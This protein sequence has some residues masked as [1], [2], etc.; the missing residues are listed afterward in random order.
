VKSQLTSLF[1]LALVTA[2]CSGSTPVAP[3]GTTAG[4]T[5]AP[6]ENGV[7][8]AFMRSTAAVPQ[9]FTSDIEWTLTRDQCPALWSNSV[10]GT[11]VSRTKVRIDSLGN[12]TF[13]ISKTETVV[14]TATDEEQR[15]FTFNYVD[16]QQQRAGSSFAFNATNTFTLVGPGGAALRLSV[17]STDLFRVDAEGNVKLNSSQTRGPEGCVPLFV[18]LF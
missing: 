9:V 7:G 1:I 15:R 4:T 17:G 11:G 14:G 10:T 12:G 13:H 8:S 6:R 2:G 3:S 16:T 18:P 5:A